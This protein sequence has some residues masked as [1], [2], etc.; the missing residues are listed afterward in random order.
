MQI[1][2]ISHYLDDPNSIS[3]HFEGLDA[4]MMEANPSVMQAFASSN[5]SSVHFALRWEIMLF[6]D[7]HNFEGLMLIWDNII[8]HHT[9]ASS[10]IEALCIAHFKQA[11]SESLSD[12]QH[13]KKWDY[14][15]L[16]L[17]ADKEF[18][19]GGSILNNVWKTFALC[20]IVGVVFIGQAA[21]H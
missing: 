15:K 11:P 19:K 16:L 7:E 18:N 20:A 9:C 17:D 6:A 21:M 14:K 8:A 13:F 3:A 2:N 12:L 5:Q 1:S 4:R 10:Y